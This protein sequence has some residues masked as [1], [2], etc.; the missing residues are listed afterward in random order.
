MKDGTNKITVAK[1]KNLG[2][3]TRQKGSATD[4][5][6][7]TKQFSAIRVI[8]GKF[9]GFGHQNVNFTASSHKSC[10]MESVRQNIAYRCDLCPESHRNSL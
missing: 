5:T 8:R 1:N 7:Y 3:D 4:F 2:M 6:N 9:F 10:W